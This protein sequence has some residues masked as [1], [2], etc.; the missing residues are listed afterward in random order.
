M[1]IATNPTPC[2]AVPKIRWS[3]A[4]TVTAGSTGAGELPRRSS[5]IPSS[6]PARRQFVD[7]GTVAAEGSI[8]K[9]PTTR[10]ARASAELLSQTATSIVSEPPSRDRAYARRRTG[11]RASTSSNG[12]GSR[13]TRGDLARKSSDGGAKEKPGRTTASFHDPSPARE[14][15]S[16]KGDRRT[17]KAISIYVYF[18]GNTQTR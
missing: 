9:R 6:P 14:P 18:E 4:N 15:P 8:S 13:V 16:T 17:R 7:D 12:G 5:C 1:S 10:V 11:G 2:G 3:S